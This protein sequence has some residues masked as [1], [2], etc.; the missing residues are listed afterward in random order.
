MFCVDLRNENEKTSWVRW[1]QL[2]VEFST[3]WLGHVRPDLQCVSAVLLPF[4]L[5]LATKKW[6]NLQKTAQLEK[7]GKLVRSRRG[8]RML[9]DGKRML[10]VDFLKDPK[11]HLTSF[12]HQK[13]W[14]FELPWEKW[15]KGWRCLLQNPLEFSQRPRM[16]SG[17]AS[18]PLQQMSGWLT[19]LVPKWSSLKVAEHVLDCFL[20][21]LF[22]LWLHFILLSLA[23]VRILY[24]TWGD[25][26]SC[27]L[28][29]STQLVCSHMKFHHVSS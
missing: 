13:Q 4:G 8:Q 11:G 24:T 16:S 21:S 19:S 9:K 17:A 3:R 5:K 7:R 2:K 25:F 10:K 1:R 26:S 14:C 23:V 6:Q 29:Q 27:S 12:Y 28:A 22:F 18:S 20:A 15:R